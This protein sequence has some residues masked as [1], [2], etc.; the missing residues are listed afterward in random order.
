MRNVV[1]IA[2]FVLALVLIGATSFAQEGPKDH[3]HKDKGPKAEK[4]FDKMDADKNGIISESEAKDMHEKRSEKMA[5][6]GKEMKP[7]KSIYENFATIDKN[8]DGGITLQELKDEIAARKPSPENFI[9]KFDEDGDAK[10][11]KDEALAAKEHQLERLEKRKEK[12]IEKSLF[13]RFDD[14]D[15]DGDGELS[16]A[17]LDADIAK[18]PDPKNPDRKKPSGAK[19]VKKLD[20]NED[21][22]ISKDEAEEHHNK[23]LEKADKHKE[24][25]V[26]DQFSEIDTDSDGYLTAEELQAFKEKKKAEKESRKGEK[27]GN[28]PTK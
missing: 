4:I 26:Y 25:N 21:G 13:T 23:K 17:E 5:E 15:T 11:N 18:M 8:S 9:K 12:F 1:V 6:K 27:K 2:G 20:S 7:G 3:K 14:I 19:V 22:S 28:F 16:T 24:K 10:M